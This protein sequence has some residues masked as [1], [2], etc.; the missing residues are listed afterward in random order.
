MLSPGK[1]R[2]EGGARSRFSPLLITTA[3][4][5]VQLPVGAYNDE[6]GR[7]VADGWSSTVCNL[8]SK[9]N[10]LNSRNM[11]THARLTD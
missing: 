9:N 5:S 7:E 11:R 10:F 1:G 8:Y 3:F 4:D 2:G 6:L